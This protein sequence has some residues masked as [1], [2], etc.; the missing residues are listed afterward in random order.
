MRNEKSETRHLAIKIL[1]NE[2]GTRSIDIGKY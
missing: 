2:K 1:C